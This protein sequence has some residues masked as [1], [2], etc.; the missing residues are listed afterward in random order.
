MVL[1][2]F[3]FSKNVLNRLI[4]HSYRSLTLYQIK[5]IGLPQSNLKEFTDYE[6]KVVHIMKF[7]Q[8]WLP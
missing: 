7:V 2:I 3:V 5:Q 1:S 6:L 8:D 4:P